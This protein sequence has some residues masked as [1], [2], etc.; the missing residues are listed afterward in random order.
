MKNSF[1]KKLTRT[2]ATI[3]SAVLKSFLIPRIENV[4]ENEVK[5]THS[6]LAQEVEKFILSPEKISVK[7]RIFPVSFLYILICIVFLKNLVQ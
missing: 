3:T 4:I 6:D 2:A 1:V 5:I 7:V